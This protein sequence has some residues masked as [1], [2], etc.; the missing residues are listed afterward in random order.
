[1]RVC[2][3]AFRSLAYEPLESSARIVHGL[4]GKNSP[5][6]FCFG[7]LVDSARDR[8][9]IQDNEIGMG[10]GRKR[11]DAVPSQQPCSIARP[12]RYG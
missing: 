1:M 9:A 12:H 3:G 5:Q 6:Y 10:I 8:I 11:A 2:R 7:D 4:A